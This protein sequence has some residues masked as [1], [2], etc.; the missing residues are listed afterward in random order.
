MTTGKTVDNLKVGQV[1]EGATTPSLCG[2]A[3]STIW[4]VLNE[5]V[6]SED[7]EGERS[8][9]TQI[10]RNYLRRKRRSASNPVRASTDIS[11]LASCPVS[12]INE[13]SVVD[14]EL[15]I[16][17]S[18]RFASSGVDSGEEC[19]P[20]DF[21]PSLGDWSTVGPCTMVPIYA[22]NGD[23]LPIC[24]PHSAVVDGEIELSK[25]RLPEVK[26]YEEFSDYWQ[27]AYHH[28]SEGCPPEGFIDWFSDIFD[29]ARHSLTTLA[30]G[31]YRSYS[32]KSLRWR[33]AELFEKLPSSCEQ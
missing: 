13:R 28:A 9:I 3:T 22:F 31:R 24:G 10:V 33:L 21:D 25:T 15:I 18:G 20:R 8:S 5:P 23:P 4:D 6:E 12:P 17:T 14:Q 19:I 30:S 26:P 2:Y 11:E 7:F 1:W 16:P 27:R 32:L 29:R